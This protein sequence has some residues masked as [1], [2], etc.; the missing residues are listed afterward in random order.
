MNSK[1]TNLLSKVIIFWFP[2]ELSIVYI[3]KYFIKNKIEKCVTFPK[4]LNP[5]PNLY[6][7]LN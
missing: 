5:F 4:E 6:I 3:R 2:F 7:E 1:K